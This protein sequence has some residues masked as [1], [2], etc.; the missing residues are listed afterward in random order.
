ML[1]CCNYF[2]S[3]A[4]ALTTVPLFPTADG[5]VTFIIDLSQVKDTRSKGLLNQTSGLY[6]W[7]W[8]G[9]DRNNN[10][11][12]FGP[13]GQTDFSKAYTPGMLTPLA[14]NIWSIKLTP[15]K[16]LTIPPGKTVAWM[17]I[18]VKNADGTAQTE[19]FI[20]DLYQSNKLHVNFTTPVQK[21][22]FVNASETLT[23]KASASAVSNLT[24]SVDGNITA[25]ATDT[26]LV[27]AVNAGNTPNQRRTVKVT[28]VA[29]GQQ[30]TDEFSFTVS[31]SP[32]VASLLLGL[33]NGINYT[34]PTSVTLVLFA[35][36]KKFVYVLG[37]FN[38]WD[39]QS[40]ALM[41]RTPDGQTY[42]LEIKNLTLQK[43]YAFQYLIDGSITVGDPYC[44]KIL[45]RNNDKY[46]PAATYPGLMPFPENATG[47]IVSVLQTGKMA[48]DW[49]N[50]NFKRPAKENLVIY[51]LLVRDFT[52]AKWY[53][54]MSDTLPY[55][56]RLGINAIE[57]MPV[58][59]FSGNDS[60]GYNPTYYFAPDK[61][62]GTPDDLKKF[63]DTCHE[64]GIAV[65]LDMVLNQADYEFP[66][67]K[68]YWNETQ[69]SSNSPMFNQQAT[70]PFSVFFDFNHEAVATQDFADRVT[71]F[72]LTEYHID[73]YRF[74]LSKGFTQK[75]SGNDVVLWS[76][77]DASRVAIWKR[78]YNKIRDIDS[79]AYVILEHFAEDKE[80]SELTNYGMMVWDNLNGGFREMIKNGN[81]DFNRLSWK[82]HNGFRT[83]AAIGYMESHD[84]ERL[85]Y[86]AL[87]NGGIGNGYTVKTIP[88]A[89]ERVKAAT[90]LFMLTPGP[91]MI[92]QFGEL[93][94]DISINE[95]GRTGAKP[96]RWDYLNNPD[97]QKLYK[98]FS[99]LIRLKQDLPV[100]RSSDFLIEATSD[101]VKKLT[102]SDA[103]MKVKVVA[104]MDM[105][106][107]KI[108]LPDGKWFDY[109]TGREIVV[110]SGDPLRVFKPSEFHILTSVKLPIP[111][112]ELVPWQFEIITSTE[113]RAPQPELVVSPN[114]TQ[115]LLTARWQSSYTGGIQLWIYDISGRLVKESVFIKKKISVEQTLPVSYLKRGLYLLKITEGE[116]TMIRKWVKD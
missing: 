22:F 46:I 75:N 82:A 24:I 76:S 72:W 64:N 89:L 47:D 54:T 8:G 70:H 20:V 77:Y 28:A 114:P 10:T 66:Y 104:N 9:S 103:S 37:D 105:N 94:Y 15:D 34:S 111:E 97:R 29:N 78:I 33:N 90:A 2:N 25:N 51:E 3:A 68:M 57:L 80:E 40:T 102:V 7:T 86:D 30:A 93:G 56:K 83:P 39:P 21:H 14:A 87:A 109:F 85:V 60:W 27:T 55:L 88:S 53:Q 115:D 49:K 13:A 107:R 113:T 11:S 43:E 62:Y 108:G 65:L 42:W 32:Q 71:S 4:Q 12:E 67:V 100:F 44:E 112:A 26:I 36:D 61:A 73:G 45:D 79:S 1:L 17:G 18:L 23:V 110:A 6:I 74:D 52:S 35:P 59:E 63:I 48:Y 91:K 81:G 58:T 116:K 101:P 99:T 106:E 98:V 69:P 5:E 96:I 31:P 84:E 38:Q 95:N 92:W 41:N 16:Y 19:D 50:G